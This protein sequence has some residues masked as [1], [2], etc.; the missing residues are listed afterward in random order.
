MTFAYHTAAKGD[1][2]MFDF[3]QKKSSGAV[4]FSKRLAF[5]GLLHQQLNREPGSNVMAIS[6]AVLE[7]NDSALCDA[8]MLCL[9][10]SFLRTEDGKIAKPLYFLKQITSMALWE[11]RE[12]DLKVLGKEDRN[13]HPCLSI[14]IPGGQS[15]D[16]DCPIHYR[17]WFALDFPGMPLHWDMMDAKGNILRSLDVSEVR[18]S[19]MAG[20]K[21]Q[22][23]YPGKMR[24]THYAY[25][26]PKSRSGPTS[27]IVIGDY[28][29]K[30]V[31][32][33]NVTNEEMFTIDPGLVEVIHDVDNNRN[34][35]V[36]PV[37]Q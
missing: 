15:F 5:N 18:T 7:A 35:F 32:I 33:N 3:L 6:K 13:G 28:E 9:L 36:R 34:I 21:I 10:Y 11:E 1:S 16:Y 31:V 19:G 30:S 22:F 26:D 12:K 37:K 25:A 27:A 2:W 20:G 23:P 17:V 8:D 29:M 24:F 14:E 4:V